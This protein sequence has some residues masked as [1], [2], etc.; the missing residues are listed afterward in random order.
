M[1]S[2]AG[3]KATSVQRYHPAGPDPGIGEYIGYDFLEFARGIELNEN[4]A[5]KEID[6]LLQAQEKIFGIINNS[7]M[8]DE[9]KEKV[10]QYIHRRM[11]LL[12]MTDKP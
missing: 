1:I 6:K 2:L 9:H 12:D 3:Q 7:Y 4:L 8:S 11:V 5:K 10:T